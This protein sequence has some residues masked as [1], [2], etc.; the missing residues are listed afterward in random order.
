MQ[1]KLGTNLARTP[2]GSEQR[3]SSEFSRQQLGQ[4]VD[5]Q[6]NGLDEDGLPMPPL[7]DIVQQPKMPGNLGINDM[8][9]PL[10]NL[11]QLTMSLSSSTDTQMVVADSVLGKRGAEEEVQGNQLELSL[12]LNYANQGG[13]KLRK[14]TVGDASKQA[15]EQGETEEE[16]GRK[17]V[18][19][20]AA[21]G[22][23]APG[24]L[25][26]PNVWSRQKQ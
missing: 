12:A 11:S 14:G 17:K 16:R 7:E 15:A 8:I 18:K 6:D 10:R 25:T 19:K 13:G 1:L 5:M 4:D 2:C 9:P 26:R 23:G 3:S 22:L 21:T 20:Q 24:Q